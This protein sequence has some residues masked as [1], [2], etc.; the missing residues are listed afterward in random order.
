MDRMEE[1]A[2]ASPG[3]DSQGKV[4]MVKQEGDEDPCK[5]LAA[6][7][8]RKVILQKVARRRFTIRQNSVRRFRAGRAALLEV[9]GFW[10]KSNVVIGKTAFVRLCQSV[11]SEIGGRRLRFEGAATDAIQEAC[12][13]FLI[14]YFTALNL[15]ANRAN[16]DTVMTTDAALL[17]QSMNVLEPTPNEK[18]TSN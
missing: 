12:E 18:P 7:A 3:N 10:K 5:P 15:I 14:N 17:K 9:D 8:T 1:T 4:A 16:R 11:A 6:T 13:A 2:R